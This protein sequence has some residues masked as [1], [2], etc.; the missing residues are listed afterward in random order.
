[1]LTFDPCFVKYIFSNW[2]EF[3]AG[4]RVDTD[5]VLYQVWCWDD[6]G[7]MPMHL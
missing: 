7:I 2:A 3:F 6:Y 1:M 5:L 4:N